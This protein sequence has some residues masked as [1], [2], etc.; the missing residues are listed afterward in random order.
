MEGGNGKNKTKSI[1]IPSR[2]LE[3]KVLKQFG[4]TFIIKPIPLEEQYLNKSS[5]KSTIPANFRSYDFYT[6]KQPSVY[7]DTG[8]GLQQSRLSSYPS[9]IDIDSRKQTLISAGASILRSYGSSNGSQTS[10][11]TN[12]P[13][14]V[15]SSSSGNQSSFTFGK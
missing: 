5:S 6:R 8:S 11:I 4:V 12:K 10:G 7:S 2:N 1:P 3:R 9:K 15:S 14:C 13:D